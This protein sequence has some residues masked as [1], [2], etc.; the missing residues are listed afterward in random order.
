MS[1]CV[2]EL[3]IQEMCNDFSFCMSLFFCLS[4]MQLHRLTLAMPALEWS[5]ICIFT[6]EKICLGVFALRQEKQK[7]ERMIKSMART[8]K[9]WKHKLC[10]MKR[11][12]YK[13][14]KSETKNKNVTDDNFRGWRFFLIKSSWKF[15]EKRKKKR[16]ISC[17]DKGKEKR[18]IH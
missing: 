3:M 7:S 16:K 1:S 4:V 17:W 9:L 14:W 10:C 18:K 13:C 5:Q 12:T 8:N 6:L 15:P 11:K 2:N